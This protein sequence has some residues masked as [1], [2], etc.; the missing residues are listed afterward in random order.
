MAEIV[1]LRQHRKA[2]ARADRQEQADKNRVQHGLSK[3]EKQLAK[4][5]NELEGSRLTGKQLDEDD[6]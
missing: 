4:R 6:R 1:N 5:Q 2:K 3:A